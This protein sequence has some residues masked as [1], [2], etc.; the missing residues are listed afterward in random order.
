MVLT[1]GS[2][3][4]FFIVLG[5]AITSL[6]QLSAVRHHA[7]TPRRLADILAVCK[8]TELRARAGLHFDSVY[9]G[10]SLEDL[11]ASGDNS[12][13]PLRPPWHLLRGAIHAYTVK[14]IDG[15]LGGLRR[16]K[17]EDLELSADNPV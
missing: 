16:M 17:V 9:S 15:E 3:P 2:E 10:C 14:S 1:P 11:E 4:G 13:R 12:V 7:K 8:K 6:V 5:R